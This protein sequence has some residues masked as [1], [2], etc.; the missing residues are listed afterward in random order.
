MK[1]KRLFVI[2][3]LSLLTLL[4]A[5]TN[6]ITADKAYKYVGQ[7]KTVCG[8]VESVFYSYRSN[9]KP[10]FLNIDKAYPNNEFMIVIWGNNRY[11]FKPTPEKKYLKKKICVT[12]RIK[13]YKG[14]SEI[15]VTDPSQIIIK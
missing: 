9:G 15:I 2:F 3:I 11:K 1:T 12:G 6:T 13:M 8:T 7:T 4:Y 5:Q 14:T 10:T